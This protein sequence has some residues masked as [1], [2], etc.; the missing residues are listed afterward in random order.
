MKIQLFSLFTILIHTISFSQTRPND[1]LRCHGILEDRVL[2][3]IL[4]AYKNKPEKPKLVLKKEQAIIC[5]TEMMRESERALCE[6]AEMILKKYPFVI[7][8]I[9]SQTKNHP[10]Y[11][12]AEAFWMDK[13]KD[14]SDKSLQLYRDTKLEQ[15]V[16]KGNHSYFSFVII[17]D[18]TKESTEKVKLVMRFPGEV[19]T[20]KYRLPSIQE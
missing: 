18:K 6:N 8:E 11:L 1:T 2:A 9:K 20:K 4:D 14:K 10:N 17:S 15:F 5:G 12:K 3:K 7:G 13:K 19:I 16:N